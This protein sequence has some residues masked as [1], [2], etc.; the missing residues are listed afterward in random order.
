KMTDN[1]QFGAPQ[2]LPLPFD[3]AILKTANDAL[4]AAISAALGGDRQATAQRNREKEVVVRLLVQLGHYVEA[5]CKDD[6]TIFLSSGFTAAVTAKTAAPP[7]SESIRKIEPGPISGQ[8]LI[9]LMR[10]L[11]AGSYE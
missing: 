9:I 6:M 4:S 1:P 5:N 10:L 7:V 3:L 2:T 11:G 8:L